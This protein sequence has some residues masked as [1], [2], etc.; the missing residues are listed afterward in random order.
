MNEILNI[1]HFIKNID[2]IIYPLIIVFGGSFLFYCFP[3]SFVPDY[4][5]IKHYSKIYELFS[6]IISSLVSL[7]GI[8]ITVSLVA[9][10][11]FKQKSGID[12]QKS[13][14]VNRLNA[15]YISFTVFTILLSIVSSIIISNSN[16]TYKEVS[17]IYYN[18]ILFICVITCLF[19]IAF[20]LFSSLRPDK[21]AYSELNKINSKSIII[22]WIPKEGI[23]K[24][25]EYLE[26]DPLLKIENIVIALITVKDSIKARAIIYKVTIKLTELIIS[27]K[28]IWDK[29]Y[30]IDR[31][32]SFYIKIIDFSLLQPNNSTV[33]KSIWFA[34]DEMY[35]LTAELKET[36]YHFEKFNKK[37][38]ERYFNRL[39]QTNNEE[40]LYDGIETI[41]NI[42]QKQ[43]LINMPNDENIPSL[44]TLR[45]SID[46]TFKYPHNYSKEE[47]LNM[48]HF[49]EVAVQLM[50]NFSFL[51]NKGIIVNK[52][53]LINKCIEQLNDLNFRFHLKGVGVYIQSFF[54]ISTANTIYDYAYLAFKRDVFIEGHDA[55]QL[56]PSLFENLIEEKH[57]AARTILQKYC[58]FIINLQ[59]I[60]K[61][62]RWFLGGLTIGNII[63]T[64]GELGSIARTCVLKYSNGKVIQDCLEDC[65]NTFNILKEY[66]EQNPPENFGYYEVIKWQFENIL[67]NMTEYK[68]TDN[69]TIRNIESIIASFKNRNEIYR[70]A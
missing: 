15:Y 58:Y 22:Q 53:E 11:F 47:I 2:F 26:N 16:P 60:N 8:Y 45:S 39:I 31:L 49:N 13:F 59:K 37:F 66:Y 44:N 52:P 40:T 18:A 54:Y 12:F 61:L 23:D 30:I 32:I 43:V 5:D 69:K 51:L 4:F 33:L 27:E 1:K 3:F 6:L 10:E 70:K 62:D 57:P 21:I 56:T 29:E 68:I 20:N 24:Q 65:I 38:F 48:S 25:S 36:A 63:T 9:Y 50:N 46:K 7:I 42:I 34:I 19:P 67:E 17:I 41:K 14:L 28:D 55:K 35:S 64:E